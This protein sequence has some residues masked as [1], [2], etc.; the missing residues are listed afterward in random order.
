[1][2]CVTDEI[3]SA[4]VDGEATEQEA[5]HVR[6]CVDCG[7]RLEALL[8]ME[9]GLRSL[10]L[11]QEAPPPALRG[12]LRGLRAHARRPLRWASR[13]AVGGVT[14][15]LVVASLFLSPESGRVPEALADQ[16][17]SS[18]LRAFT[19]GDGSGCHVESS[20]PAV[21]SGWLEGAVAGPIEVPAPLADARLVGARRCQL[22]GEATPAVVFR[23]EEA[24][25]TVFLP[26]PGT[27]AFEACERSLGTCTEGRDGQTVCVL[28]GETGAPMVVVGALPGPRLCEVV[29]S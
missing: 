29:G 8:A 19:T 18:H 10:A 9:R 28:P 14:V 6:A 11:A 22:F 4:L 24:P 27:A 3:L 20:D 5:S 26:Q 16:A 21:L 13:A 15:A 7:E 17:I 12:T 23:T 25:V 1:M 2:S